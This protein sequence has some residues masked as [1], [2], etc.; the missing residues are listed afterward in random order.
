MSARK[1]L[2]V[3]RLEV[4]VVDH[5]NASRYAGYAR[6]KF[7]SPHAKVLRITMQS[8]IRWTKYSL[9]NW[10]RRAGPAFDT[11]LALEMLGF[12]GPEASEGLASHL[13]KRKPAFPPN[14][15]V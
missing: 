4:T 11:S 2:T 12:T 3:T 8:A 15:T 6:L 10:L 9:N 7:D 13:Q 5:D 1:L 14:S